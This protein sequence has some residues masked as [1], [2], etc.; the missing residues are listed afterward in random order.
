MK[1]RQWNFSADRFNINKQKTHKT[2]K[3][4]PN[5]FELEK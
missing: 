1:W 4:D 3:I 2:D 5:S